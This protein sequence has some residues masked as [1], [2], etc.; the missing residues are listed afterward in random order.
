MDDVD[1]VLSRRRLAGISTL[2]LRCCTVVDGKLDE[3]CEMMADDE[4][5]FLEKKSKKIKHMSALT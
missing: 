4:N 5:I 2:T 1:G 3:L